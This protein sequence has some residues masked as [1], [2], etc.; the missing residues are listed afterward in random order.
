M[1]KATKNKIIATIMSFLLIILTAPS[2]LAKETNMDKILDEVQVDIGDEDTFYSIIALVKMKTTEQYVD[3]NQDRDFVPSP[4]VFYRVRDVAQ[5]DNKPILNKN[6]E[7]GIFS[8]SIVGGEIGLIKFDNTVEDETTGLF[9]LSIAKENIPNEIVFEYGYSYRSVAEIND[10]TFDNFI[11]LSTGSPAK[12]IKLTPKEGKKLNITREVADKK[13]EEMSVEEYNRINREKLKRLYE[14]GKPGD[15]TEPLPQDVKTN[16]EVKH[17][18]VLE[19]ESAKST[20]TDKTTGRLENKNDNVAKDDNVED[21]EKEKDTESKGNIE[22]KDN[23]ESAENED[24]YKHH[25]HAD[26]E[27]HNHGHTEKMQT[28]KQKENVDISKVE[29]DVEKMERSD[30]LYSL[31]YPLIFGSIVLIL[32][33]VLVVYTKKHKS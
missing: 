29:T 23:V 4:T 12:V 28:E 27:T 8:E 33:V 20:Q 9:V 15:Q 13:D 2:L 6:L 25:E 30:G 1:Q 7:A 32:V 17:T 11:E 10:Y 22:S 19:K 31:K 5:L 24:E 3:S 18:A 14:T 21:T 26:S 16:Q